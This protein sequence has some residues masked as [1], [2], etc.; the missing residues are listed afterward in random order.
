MNHTILF[1]LFLIDFSQTYNKEFILNEESLTRLNTL[2]QYFLKN[3]DFFKSP[4]VSDL[5]HPSFDKGLLLIGDLGT[6]KTAMLN[7]L[8]QVLRKTNILYTIPHHVI[9]V[10]Q[11]YEATE[12]PADRAKFFKDFSEARRF[13][14]DILTEDKASN[15]G[16]KYIFKDIL[17]QRYDKRVLTL[18]TCNFDPE[19]GDD[20]NAGIKQFYHKYGSRIYDRLFEMFNIV[21]FR[22]VSYRR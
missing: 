15:Y 14:D 19:Y 7:I 11:K 8:L 3:E 9:E 5:S 4:I 22:G 16:T 18:M 6:G 17:E 21:V 12:N 2:I 10:N 13:F 1:K 20:L